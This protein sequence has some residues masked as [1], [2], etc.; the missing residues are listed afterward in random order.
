[1]PNLL[2]CHYSEPFPFSFFCAE[3]NL[4]L[5]LPSFSSMTCLSQS[6][7]GDFGF[8]SRKK[9]R[10]HSFGDY[11]QISSFFP[12]SSSPLSGRVTRYFPRL[13]PGRRCPFQFFF[14]QEGNS[15]L[16]R[17]LRRCRQTFHSVLLKPFQ[18]ILPLSCTPDTPACPSP[19]S[20]LFSDAAG[21]S[22]AGIPSEYGEYLAPTSFLFRHRRVAGAFL[23]P[24]SATSAEAHPGI[25]VF[26]LPSARRSMKITLPALSLFCREAL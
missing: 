25:S 1:M 6:W 2:F 23:S 15:R 7:L 17:Q 9:K 16:A 5:W 4:I 13:D 24:F 10:R 3:R 22:A 18:R 14:L 20:L 21:S 19:L 26:S 11:A 12:I 8:F